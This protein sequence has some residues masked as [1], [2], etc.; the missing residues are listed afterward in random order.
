MRTSNQLCKGC[1]RAR[2]LERDRTS[3]SIYSSE[4]QWL[5]QLS[6]AMASFSIAGTWVFSSIQPGVIQIWTRIKIWMFATNN[7]GQC[8]LVALLS[9]VTVTRLFMYVDVFK[10]KTM[11]NDRYDRFFRYT[12]IVYWRTTYVIIKDPNRVPPTRWMRWFQAIS[13]RLPS[14]TNKYLEFQS[15]KTMNSLRFTLSFPLLKPR[16]VLQSI[17]KRDSTEQL[18]RWWNSWVW[19]LIINCSLDKK[20]AEH[21]RNGLHQ[22]PNCSRQLAKLSFYLWL[23]CFLVLLA[24]QINTVFNKPVPDSYFIAAACVDLAAG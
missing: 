22:N 17:S 14:A 24:V 11:L 3:Y 20:I 5:L 15:M 19:I 4:T 21:A 6:Y 1:F 9:K 13:T 12:M 16:K 2:I 18:W 7:K 23:T 8:L 10:R